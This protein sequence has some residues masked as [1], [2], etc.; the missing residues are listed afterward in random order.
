MGYVFR[1]HFARFAPFVLAAFFLTVARVVCELEV[2]NLMSDIVDTGIV[3]GDMDF[4]VRTGGFM[5]LWALGAM[6]ADLLNDLCAARAGMGLGRELRSAL[7]RR[8]FELS[9]SQVE[10]FG[11]S[12]LIT[13][14]TNDVQ[15]L[16]RFVQ[17]SM[18]IA[19]MSPVMLVGAAFMAYAK[20]PELS[21]VVFSAIP[22]IVVL[23]FA[24]M[25]LVM[26]LLRSLQA[27]IDA[28]NRVTREQLTG[29][30]VVRAL[31]REGFEEARFAKA[32]RDL[33]ETNVSVARRVATLMPGISLVLNAATV[34]IVWCAAGLVDAGSFAVGDM[35]AL[36]QYAMQVLI[37]VMMLSA[38]FMIWP[39]AAAAAERIE[40]VLVSE[41]AVKDPDGT[42]AAH[43]GEELVSGQAAREQEMRGREA[44]APRPCEVSFEHVDFSFPGASSPALSDVDLALEPGRVYALVG[45]TGSGKSTL[46]DLLLRFHDTSGGAVKIDGR[47]VRDMVQDEL[48]ALVS[49]VPQ[50]TVLFSGTIA[51]NIAY[52]A[53]DATDAQIE[54]AARAAC[55]WDFIE[56]REDG[57]STR[58]TQAASGLSGG[59]RQRIAI[60][61]ALCKPAGLFV[62][63]DS[64]SALDFK[65]DAQVRRNLKEATGGATVLI[66]AQRVAAA[67]DADEV[68]VLDA[69]RVVAVGAHDELVESCEVYRE[70]VASQIDGEVGAGA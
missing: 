14:T 32:N 61:R 57:L 17:M 56:A 59:Q 15:Q 33:A 30:R 29:V 49:Y 9:A 65:T 42:A 58:I 46:V 6:A 19:L 62:F 44:P 45:A 23:A 67:M 40:A 25:R 20:S 5:L 64:F 27:R 22:V 2:P 16:E 31:R 13:R 10:E 47:D 11:T 60:A 35:M 37:S 18:T 36:I 41:P 12:S 69:G 52:G 26:P 7:Y 34:A 39:R 70:I 28:L 50:K 1:H 21:V 48:R 66:V 3:G 4:V 24:V 51:E 43:V 63:D 68:V 38:I 54:Q 8:V 55:A 53:P